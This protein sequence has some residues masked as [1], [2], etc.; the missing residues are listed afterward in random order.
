MHTAALLDA[1]VLGFRCRRP[2]D[3]VFASLI[4]WYPTRWVRRRLRAAD[5]AAAGGQDW[6]DALLAQGLLRPADAAVLRSAQRAGNLEWALG[7]MAAANR[8]RLAYRLQ[9]VVQLAFPPVVLSLGLVVAFVALAV[10]SSLAKL[11]MRL[12]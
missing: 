9:A 8:R 4:R 6:L 2:L 5:A 11:V 10:L 1:M 12:V 3:D 7:E